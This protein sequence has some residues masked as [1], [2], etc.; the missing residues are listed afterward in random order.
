MT[1]GFEIELDMTVNC[2][3]EIVVLY[4][5]HQRLQLIIPGALGLIIAGD[6]EP[7]HI[8]GGIPV[9]VTINE[10]IGMDLILISVRGALTSLI[11]IQGFTLLQ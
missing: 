1:P 2:D 10:G 8:S 6:S 5:I 3:D 11:L 4:L 9:A 7:A